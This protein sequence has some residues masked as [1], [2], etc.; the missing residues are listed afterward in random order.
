[1]P[2][3]PESV[4]KCIQQLQQELDERRGCGGVIVKIDDTLRLI[5]RIDD[6]FD[7]ADDEGDSLHRVE[8]ALYP[9]GDATDD[10]KWLELA[11]S[12]LEGAVDEAEKS[13]S[14]ET[15]LVP[16]DYDEE[17]MAGLIAKLNA[18]FHWTVCECG[19][20]LIKDPS[21]SHC[22]ACSLIHGDDMDALEE[23]PICF[24][25]FPTNVFSKKTPCCGQAAHKKCISRC[26]KCPFCRAALS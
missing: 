4:F 7:S 18:V 5:M 10:P 17:Y 14:I 13:L 9:I 21:A 26:K 22:I 23:C 24:V 19:V 2:R 3:T 15:F 16:K 20:Q 12:S 8:L 1:M 25:D 11:D 6:E